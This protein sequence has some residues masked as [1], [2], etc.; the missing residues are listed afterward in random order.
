MKCNIKGCGKID[1]GFE[2]GETV[3][4]ATRKPQEVLG[5]PVIGQGALF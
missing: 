1:G 3:D 2:D 5:L 4:P